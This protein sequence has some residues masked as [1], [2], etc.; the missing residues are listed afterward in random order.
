MKNYKKDF[1]IIIC[2]ALI[3]PL[4]LFMFK[5]DTIEYVTAENLNEKTESIII[6]DEGKEEEF[7]S[8]EMS[9]DDIVQLTAQFMDILV[10]NIDENTYKVL[11]YDSKEGLLTT[12]ESVTTV[13]IANLFVDTY[14]EEHEDG[15]Y[16]IP[17]STP[18]WFESD[19]EY[20]IVQLDGDTVKV[21]QYNESDFYGAFEI[22]LEFTFDN[23]WKITS[24]VYP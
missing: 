23:N 3:L 4:F 18:P 21:S 8:N 15:L 7:L 9:H 17:T 16:I 6:V 2:I 5:K 1:K 10:Q 24:V 13:D 19:N 14:Y 22:E 12:F 11:N 20:D